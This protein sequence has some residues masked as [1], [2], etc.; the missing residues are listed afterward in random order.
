[1][2]FD[3]KSLIQKEDKKDKQG[4]KKSTNRRLSNRRQ[5]HKTFFNV[6]YNP[7]GITWVKTSGNTPVKL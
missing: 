2:V 5:F 4:A 1:M 3:K 7:N 6:I